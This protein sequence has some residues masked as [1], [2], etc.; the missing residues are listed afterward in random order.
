MSRTS[1]P[2]PGCGKSDRYRTADKVCKDCDHAIKSWGEH[3]AN[4]N[5]DKKL[6]T[7]IL[8]REWHWNPGFY[9]GGPR[10][11]P[12]G[13][14]ETRRSLG[15]LFWELGELSCAEK[16]E[17]C[18]A[19]DE[20]HL[21][22]SNTTYLYKR[23]DIRFPLKK[24]EQYPERCDYPASEGDG[25]S[26]NALYGRIETKLLETIQALWD[27]TA[28]FAQMSYLGGLM[29][30]KNLLLQLS[31]GEISPEKFN[32]KDIEIAKRVQKSG[33]LHQKLGRKKKA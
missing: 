4:V 22:K 12:E 24:G 20:A 19:P 9:Y 31:S 29:D 25:G 23:P 26:Y 10:Q 13:F 28:R 7:V 2:C 14:S 27:H 1:K 18:D 15:Q 32:E 3:V 5:A 16:F 21:D 6:A 8:K 11:E 33:F 17:S 30:G